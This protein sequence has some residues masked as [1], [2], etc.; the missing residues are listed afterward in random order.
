MTVPYVVNQK[1]NLYIWF[2]RFNP[3]KSVVNL[4]LANLDMVGTNAPDCNALIVIKYIFTV[5]P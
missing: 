2:D 3:R 5:T 1:I 4:L